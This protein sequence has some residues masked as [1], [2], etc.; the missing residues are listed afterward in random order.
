M[1]FTLIPWPGRKRK[2]REATAPVFGAD[3]EL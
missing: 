1:A 2:G 3:I